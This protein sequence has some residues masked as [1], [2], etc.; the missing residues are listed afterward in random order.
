MSGM[1]HWVD[2]PSSVKHGRQRL[3]CLLYEGYL[4]GDRSRTPNGYPEIEPEFQLSQL[5]AK[6]HTDSGM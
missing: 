4:K 5:V 1:S 6:G 3:S 2:V